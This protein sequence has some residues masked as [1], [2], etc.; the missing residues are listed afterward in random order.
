MY[1]DTFP[2]SEDP[3]REAELNI[4]SFKALWHRAGRLQEAGIAELMALHDAMGV[5]ELLESE[6]AHNDDG[7]ETELRP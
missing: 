1:F 7:T 5:L 6:A 3:V 2:L 4:R